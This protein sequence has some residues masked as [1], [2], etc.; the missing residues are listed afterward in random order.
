MH[1]IP[2]HT[3]HLIPWNPIVSSDLLRSL[4]N[5]VT[6]TIHGRF[7]LLNLITSSMS[8]LEAG[9]GEKNDDTVISPINLWKILDSR[10]CQN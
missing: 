5:L 2:W 6:D 1:L 7:Y 10:R 4:M 9:P 3:V 8:N